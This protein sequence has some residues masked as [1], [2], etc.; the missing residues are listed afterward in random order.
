MDGCIK[1]GR[2]S[3][4]GIIS[5]AK[6]V[7]EHREAIE[8]DLLTQTG[9]ELKDV[10]RTL[11]WGAFRS[12]LKYA[13]P[14]SALTQAVRPEV[15]EWASTTKT[16]FIL[17]D[18]YDVLAQ[19]NANLVAVGSR[20]PA[21]NVKPYPRPGKKDKDSEK[22]IGSGALP[23]D[24]LHRWFEEKRAEFN[25]R[26]STSHDHRDPGSGGGTTENYK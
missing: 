10:G 23:P 21:K 19:I 6:A 17:A 14:D 13:Q 15:S 11:S 20:K 7:D 24:E 8:F 12:F 9:H 16:N 4:G 2:G 18:I 1:A 5:L 25:A 22:H 26:S 3:R